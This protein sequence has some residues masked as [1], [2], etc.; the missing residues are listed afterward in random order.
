MPDDTLELLARINVLSERLAALERHERPLDD[1]AATA[2]TLV[3]RD[4]SGNVNGVLGTFTSGVVTPKSSGATLY[5]IDST[6]G[7]SIT[8]AN[9][10]TATPLGAGVALRGPLSV[11]S[12][13]DGVGAFLYADSGGC[14]IISDRAAIFAVAAGTA[15]KINCYVTGGALTIENKR[16][17]SITIS[18]TCWRVA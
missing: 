2:S 14:S 10:A 6:S 17:S 7:S 4:G 18:V 11:W 15:N 5:A 3:R 12:N 8:I 13:G 16:G 9:N 1:T